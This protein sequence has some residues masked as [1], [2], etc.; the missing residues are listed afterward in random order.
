[1]GYTICTVNGVTFPVETI[2]ITKSSIILGK[3]PKQALRF[4]LDPTRI[5]E[6]C[7]CIYNDIAYN[8][9]PHVTI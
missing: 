9:I 6:N 5:T 8:D 1:M 3:E 4:I 7:T 2:E